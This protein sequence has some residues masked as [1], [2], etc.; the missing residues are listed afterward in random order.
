MFD[1]VSYQSFASYTKYSSVFPKPS[2]DELRRQ[3]FARIGQRDDEEWRPVVTPDFTSEHYM[4]SNHGRVLSLPRYRDGANGPRIWKGKLLKSSPQR[5]G[6]LR[7]TIMEDNTPYQIHVHRLV[8]WAFVGPEPPESHVRHLDGDPGNNALSNLTY[9]SPWLGSHAPDGG[10]WFLLVDEALK[11]RME[12]AC[13]GDDD[14]ISLLE[15]LLHQL[16]PIS[17]DTAHG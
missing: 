6:H 2:L 17:P 8:L 14:P 9:A 13:R 11:H 16:A 15:D 4:V 1:K 12:N 5:S 3:L 7:V 10:S